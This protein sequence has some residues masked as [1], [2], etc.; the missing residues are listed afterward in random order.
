MGG[1]LGHALDLAQMTFLCRDY[2]SSA[3]VD[4]TMADPT[5]DPTLIGGETNAPGSPGKGHGGM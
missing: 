3:N 4:R 2:I 5:F 1:D